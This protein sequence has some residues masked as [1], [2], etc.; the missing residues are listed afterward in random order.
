MDST[1]IFI[2]SLILSIILS[3]PKFPPRPIHIEEH[4]QTELTNPEIIHFKLE[5]WIPD[6][7]TDTETLLNL[8]ETQ[9]KDAKAKAGKVVGF[10]YQHSCF[11]TAPVLGYVQVWLPL[12][13]LLTNGKLFCVPA[14]ALGVLPIQRISPV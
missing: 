10:F 4:F 1:F 12:R 3:K 11:D 6:R 13:G 14:M 7:G 5:V 9:Y 2:F 8:K